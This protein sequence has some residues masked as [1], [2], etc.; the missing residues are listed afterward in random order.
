MITSNEKRE[1]LEKIILLSGD[2][3]NAEQVQRLQF[4]FLLHDTDGGKLYKYRSFDRKGY[5]LKSLKTG[6]LHCSKPSSFNDPFD[7]RIGVS[8]QSLYEAK[9]TS[10]LD[11]IQD[12]FERFTQCVYGELQLEDCS[13]DEQRI[14]N[15]LIKS[16]TVMQFVS[17]T[18]FGLHT[19]EEQKECLV[20]HP[21]IISELTT[22]I[23]EDE[24]FR[25]SLGISKRQL[26]NFSTCIDP[27]K[28]LDYK[29]DRS[30][31][32][33][34]EFVGIDDDVDDIEL[35]R[36][37]SN[38]MLPDDIEAVSTLLAKLAEVDCELASRMNN[39]F[40][41]GCLAT[42]PKNRL[43]WSHYAE[44]HSGFC[45]EYDFSKVKDHVALLPIVYSEKRPL[46]LWKASFDHSQETQKAEMDKM[47][48]GLLTK[49]KAWEYEN[50]WRILIDSKMP[51]DLQLP[52]S[53][54]YL[55]ASISERNKKRL[56][57]IA[58]KKRIP[59]KQMKTDRG[60]YDLHIETITNT[61]EQ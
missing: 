58:N 6:T 37:L 14:I 43:M 61:E 47:I 5:S 15:K 50:E 32:E 56:L 27:Q 42:S 49:D 8:F 33:I 36:L 3:A 35:T 59:V 17:D 60:A 22:I 30:L 29:D 46:M 53:A 1:F 39:L 12:V 40:L 21:K 48:L 18:K 4:D 52:I 16:D 55:G 38:K 28:I 25:K 13:V 26:Q 20:K 10:E 57:K 44:S 24:V 34:A 51:A 54:I 9:E 7:F 31:K 41:I 19:V 2:Q 23:V 45:V 11:L